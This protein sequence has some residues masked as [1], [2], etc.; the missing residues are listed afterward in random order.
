MN[1]TNNFECYMKPGL[2]GLPGTS[3]PAYRGFLW[4]TKKMKT[5]APVAILKTL[6]FLPNL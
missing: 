4:V 1:G 3:I 6:H 2:K 5:I